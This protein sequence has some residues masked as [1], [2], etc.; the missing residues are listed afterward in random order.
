M[1]D[2]DPRDR[3][4]RA[5][6]ADRYDRAAE[7]Y[8][9]SAHARLAGGIGRADAPFPDTTRVGRPLVQLALAALC[10]RLA[11]ADDRARWRAAEGLAIAGDAREAIATDDIERGAFLEYTGDLRAVVG[12]DEKAQNAYDRAADAYEQAAAD[13]AGKRTASPP[14]KPGTDFLAQ[15]SRPDDLTWDD[16]HSASDPLGSR[17]RTRKARVPSLVERTVAEGD[18]RAP[19]GSTEYNTGRFRCPECGSDDVNYVA[20]TTLCLRCGA[21]VDTT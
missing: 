8:T 17:V 13:D 11:G 7:F 18:L 1:T 9:E 10:Y 6:A 20:E 21:E 14:L 12:D 16:I 5:V 2:L 19:R 15:L 3:A 4:I